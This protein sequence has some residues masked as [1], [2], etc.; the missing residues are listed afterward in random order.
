MLVVTTGVSLPNG[1]P[2]RCRQ[3][4]LGSI[5]REALSFGPGRTPPRDISTLHDKDIR[6]AEVRIGPRHNRNSKPRQWM[7]SRRECSRC[8]AIILPLGNGLMAEHGA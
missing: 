5:E 7:S 1:R 6:Q 2:L 4:S 3:G 8:P